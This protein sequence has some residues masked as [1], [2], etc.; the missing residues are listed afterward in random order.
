[1]AR[2]TFELPGVKAALAREPLAQP[3]TTPEKHGARRDILLLVGALLLISLSI[4]QSLYIVFTRQA[5]ISHEDIVAELRPMVTYLETQL[6]KNGEPPLPLSI[7]GQMKSAHRTKALFYYPSKDGFALSVY[8]QMIGKRGHTLYYLSSEGKWYRFRSDLV[9]DDV[10]R[11]FRRTIKGRPVIVY[12]YDGGD[13]TGAQVD[14][15]TFWY[16]LACQDG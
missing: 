10:G 5:M 15:K 3:G 4:A 13:W 14:E 6:A 9:C 1:M 16:N 8:E 7:A 12:M 11:L 2:P